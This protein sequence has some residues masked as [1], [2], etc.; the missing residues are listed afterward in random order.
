MELDRR[1]IIPAN[2]SGRYYFS[3]LVM[4]LR[5][6]EQD[7]NK[8]IAVVTWQAG[9]YLSCEQQRYSRR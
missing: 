1:L 6:R 3:I 5:K 8:I 4:L 2:L 9:R 7:F